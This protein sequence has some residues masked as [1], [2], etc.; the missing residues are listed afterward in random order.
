MKNDEDIIVTHKFY[1][2]LPTY[3]ND[4]CPLSMSTTCDSADT[5]SAAAV[6]P[7]QRAHVGMI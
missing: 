5:V 2:I 4:L 7:A 3:A 6:S 1:I